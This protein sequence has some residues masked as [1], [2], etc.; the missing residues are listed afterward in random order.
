[1]MN[2]LSTN[3]EKKVIQDFGDEWNNFDQSSIK[4]YDL[5]KA[6][7]QYFNIFPK[8]H[9]SKD[10]EGFDMGCGSG[11]WAKIIAPYVKRLNC[12]DPSAKALKVAKNNSMYAS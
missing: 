3:L 10:V 2:K 12:L 6:F 11:R 8:S 4:D 7:N 9:F 5:R 1:M